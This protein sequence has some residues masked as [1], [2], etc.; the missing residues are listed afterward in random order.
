MFQKKERLATKRKQPGR[1]WNP[2]G[3]I[4]T[5]PITLDTDSHL[6]EAHDEEAVERLEPRY[7]DVTC[8]DV[9]E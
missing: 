9:E 8:G 3:W 5:I 1:G 2:E 7:R 6:L 4:V